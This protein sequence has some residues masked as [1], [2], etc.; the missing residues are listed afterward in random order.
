MPPSDTDPLTAAMREMRMRDTGKRI[1]LAIS[2]FM[3]ATCFLVGLWPA[4]ALYLWLCPK[5]AGNAFL[6]ALLIVACVY[7]FAICYLVGVLLWRIIVPVPKEGFHRVKGPDGR[8]SRDVQILMLNIL[9]T[10][11]RYSPPWSGM[12]SSALIH[13][14]PLTFIFKRLFSPHMHSITM[15]DTNQIVDPYFIHTHPT[16]QIG[17]GGMFTCH[18]F[19]QR[20]VLIKPIV[21]EAGVMLGGHV[22]IGPGVHIGH[23]ALIEPGTCMQPNVIVP[24][25]ERWGGRPCVWV[26][27]LPGKAKYLRE[28][29]AQQQ[30]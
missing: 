12:L 4:C 3:F 6:T 10:K 5:V 25:Y 2:L 24:P 18:L 29:A 13:L 14:P 21:I 30:G 28:L 1:L 11:L 8:P 22:M 9:V 26:K 19:N 17:F 20:G 15:G 16:A 27:D 23:H 7:L